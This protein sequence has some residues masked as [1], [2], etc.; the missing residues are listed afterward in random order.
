MGH[1]SRP[2]RSHSEAPHPPLRG[3]FSRGE[4][5]KEKTLTSLVFRRS[6]G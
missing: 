5:V 2:G 6:G 1:V 3:T 4:K